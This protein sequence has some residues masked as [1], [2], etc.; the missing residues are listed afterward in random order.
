MSLRRTAT[1][2]A[3]VLVG[4]SAVSGSAVAASRGSTPAKPCLLVAKGPA[5]STKGQKGTNYNVIGVSGASCATGVKWLMR[6]TH[7]SSAVFNGPSGWSC[8]AIA[9]GKVRQG[10]C[11]VKGGGI[12]EWGPALKH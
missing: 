5:W 2:L 3:L 1:V 4:V 6:F 10:E 11:T 12:I 7:E 8:I 9:S